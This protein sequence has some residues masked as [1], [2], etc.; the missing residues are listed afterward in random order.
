MPRVS[1]QEAQWRIAELKRIVFSVENN[2]PKIKQT[3]ALSDTAGLDVRD[4]WDIL[5]NS[6]TPYGITVRK[7]PERKTI[8]QLTGAEINHREQIWSCGEVECPKIPRHC[9]ECSLCD[10]LF[11][12][13]HPCECQVCGS[14]FTGSNH[15]C[16]IP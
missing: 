6:I 15:S 4:Q 9:S 10:T 13:G 14:S 8:D 3:I 7:A 16:P 2:L 11:G 5:H 1:I 12:D